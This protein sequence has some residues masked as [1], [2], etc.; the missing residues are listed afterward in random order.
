MEKAQRTG[1]YSRERDKEREER[2]DLVVVPV[3]SKLPAAALV[4]QVHHALP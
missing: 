2:P 4:C 1:A 3:S